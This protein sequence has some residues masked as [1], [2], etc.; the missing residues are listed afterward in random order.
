MVDGLL[1]S[2]VS[3][4]LNGRPQQVSTIEAIILRLM[5]KGRSGS[6]RAWRALLKLQ[7]FGR[8]HGRKNLEIRFVDNEYTRAFAGPPGN[9]DNG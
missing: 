2:P 5:E 6:N 9:Q 1:L 3:I 4:T 7:Q 8:R